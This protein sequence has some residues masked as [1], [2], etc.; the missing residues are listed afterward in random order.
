MKVININRTCKFENG[1]TKKSTIKRLIADEGKMITNDS[2]NLHSVLD[3]EDD[4]GYY[5]VD[6]TSLDETF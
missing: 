3:V 5:E 6:D 1:S 2:I 4:T